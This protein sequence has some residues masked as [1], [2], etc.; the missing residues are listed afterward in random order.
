MSTPT[1]ARAAAPSGPHGGKRLS[2]LRVVIAL[3]AIAALSVGAFFAVQSFDS[4]RADGVNPWYAGYVD[5]T[6]TPTYAFET[7]ATPADKDVVL[8]FVVA[9]TD[10]PCVPSWGTAYSLDGA[11]KDL[12]LDRR[13]ARLRQSGGDALVSFGGQLNN[14]L[15]TGCTDPDALEAAYAS[16]VDRY[17][18]ST[19]DLDIEGDALADSA[20]GDRR[21]TA[22]AA[23]QTAKRAAG[24]ELAVW[25]TLPV[26][27]SGLTADATD[28]VAQM[29]DV[30][31][32]L[33]GVNVMTMNYGSSR[34]SDS[35]AD[36]SIDALKATH[37]Q[38]DALYSKAGIELN[39]A[40][41]WSKIGATPMAGQNDAKGDVFGLA[42]AQALN[43]FAV[44]QG[45]GRM[46]LW[47]LNRDV[48]CGPNYV[49]LKRVSDACSGIAQGDQTFS[50]LLSAGFSGHP[51][52]SAGSITTPDADQ[53]VVD[54][55]ATSPYPIWAEE[56][57][58][59][60]GTKIVWHGNVYQAKWWTRG[61]IPDDPVL[62]GWETP[63]TLVG[64]VLPGETPY[65]ALTLPSGTYPDWA[66]GAVYDKGDRVLFDG[67]PYE[68]K[69]WNQGES[70]EASSADPDSSPWVPLTET[71]IADLLPTP[72]P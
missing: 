50:G 41:I 56:S 39:D 59:F 57:S 21:A 58:Y 12:D 18:L 45:L 26:A 30:G 34:G 19:I 15:A 36:A 72:A 67:V 71:Q 35:M 47:S 24:D 14:E 27:P 60:K 17:E 44:Q 64:P 10:D 61:D 2:P 53:P 40:T 54:D 1:P 29:L 16:V 28:T 70:P 42:D 37:R 51:D 62:N 32:D 49:D 48:T 7:P 52:L 43:A 25:L 33:A 69:W 3:G 4:A 23:L 31:V 68:S 63:W 65:H 46:S 11:S 6:A 20:A 5:V 13:L 9:S 38:L 66:G 8:S 55:P 22:I